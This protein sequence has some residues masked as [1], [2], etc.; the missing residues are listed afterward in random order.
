MGTSQVYWEHISDGVFTNS[1]HILTYP[2]FVL[3]YRSVG[4]MAITLFVAEVCGRFNPLLQPRDV[5]TVITSA[6]VLSGL[7]IIFAD[8][9]FS[10]ILINYGLS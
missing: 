9:G 4:F 3:F 10:R 6:V 5:P 2:P 7:A 1:P 8:W